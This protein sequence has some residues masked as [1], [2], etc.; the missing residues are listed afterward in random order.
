MKT[1][2]DWHPPPDPKMVKTLSMGVADL[3]PVVP[4]TATWVKIRYQM[5]ASLPG[6]DLTA[7]L[8][9]GSMEEGV[10]VKGPDGEVFIKLR[11]PQNLSYAH[12]E[13]ITLKLKVVA[14][15]NGPSENSGKSP[16]PLV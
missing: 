8:W 12:P 1:G 13:G 10:T 3:S 9:S 5:T 4:A 16:F 6:T 15:K 2:A 11:Q 14:Y 7:R